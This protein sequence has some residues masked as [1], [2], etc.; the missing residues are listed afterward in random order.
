MGITKNRSFDIMWE[1]RAEV[2]RVVDGDTVDVRVDLGFHVHYRVRVRMYGINA[3]ESRTRNKEEKI[4]GLAAKERLEQMIEGKTVTL[5]SHG[6]GKFGRC[7][8]EITVGSVNVNT[9]LVKEGH[10]VAYYGGKR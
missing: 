7:L 5:K 8:G 9:E 6:V 1:Y 3:P 2:L 10:A 4:R